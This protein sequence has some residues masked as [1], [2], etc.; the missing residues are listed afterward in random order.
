MIVGNAKPP[1]YSK[2]KLLGYVVVLPQRT[3]VPGIGRLSISGI[4]AI[5]KFHSIKEFLDVPLSVSCAQIELKKKRQKKNKNK[6]FIQLF[7]WKF[8]VNIS[9]KN[10]F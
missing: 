6:G 9:N 5:P 10:Y 3:D 1:S 4:M 8:P 2:I 7:H